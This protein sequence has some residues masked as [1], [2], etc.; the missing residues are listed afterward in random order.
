MAGKNRDKSNAKGNEKKW[1]DR[2]LKEMATL[3]QEIGEKEKKGV[4]VNRV[5][6][7]RR[8]IT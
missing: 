8:R 7:L 3:R 2:Y 5:L 1:P 4:N 6:F